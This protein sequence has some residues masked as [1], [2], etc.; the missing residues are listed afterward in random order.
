MSFSCRFLRR[1]SF[2]YKW[3]KKLFKVT[4][5]DRGLRVKVENAASVSASVLLPCSDT[6]L[7]VVPALLHLSMYFLEQ[8]RRPCE[9]PCNAD[10]P[11]PQNVSPLKCCGSCLNAFYVHAQCPNPGSALPLSRELT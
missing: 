9:V 6:L 3:G 10:S 2:W 7:H 5:E 4:T 11:L 1:T 8:L